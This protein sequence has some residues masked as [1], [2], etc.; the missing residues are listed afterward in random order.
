VSKRGGGK[1]KGDRRGGKEGEKRP[2]RDNKD[3]NKREKG[4]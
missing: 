3:I 4:K 2:C 1:T